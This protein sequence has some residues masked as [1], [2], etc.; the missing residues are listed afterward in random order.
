MGKKKKTAE[1]KTKN[2]GEFLHLKIPL[3]VLRFFELCHVPFLVSFL[4][5]WMFSPTSLILLR[6]F[7]PRVQSAF[8]RFWGGGGGGAG[9]QPPIF[10]PSPVSRSSALLTSPYLQPSL[11]TQPSSKLRLP[12]SCSSSS[13]CS[14]LFAFMQVVKIFFDCPSFFS[15][16]RGL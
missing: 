11:N 8:L 15:C 4:K 1:S 5:T 9:C 2:K 16:Y 13:T 10:A 6:C 14:S 12:P 3:L 7:L